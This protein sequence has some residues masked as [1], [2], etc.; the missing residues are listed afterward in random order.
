MKNLQT[1]RQSVQKGFTLIELMIVV[2]IIGILAALAIPAY[3]DYTIKSRVSE[4]SSVAGA[5]KTA[6][7]V[8]WSEKGNLSNVFLA[9]TRRLGSDELGLSTVSSQYVSSVNITGTLAEPK[10]TIK[11]RSLSNLGKASARCYEM[12]P[13][14]ADV[15]AGNLT[16]AVL[17]ENA[18]TTP[19]PGSPVTPGQA[20][21]ALTEVP[22]A[23]DEGLGGNVVCTDYIQSKY[24][25]K[26]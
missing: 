14:L 12:F 26:R 19:L 10:I 25:P 1:M 22:E 8:F 5:A 2:A 15:T 6:I 11:L 24:K 9:S 7:E 18:E 4:G 16:W 3:Q 21:T 20:H 13:Y 17:G 23:Y